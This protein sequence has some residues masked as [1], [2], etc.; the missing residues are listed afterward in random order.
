[1]V[2]S[3]DFLI[4]RYCLTSTVFGY[5]I[6]LAP[7]LLE[8][9]RRSQP[10]RLEL[11]IYAH[12]VLDGNSGRFSYFGF[13]NPIEREFFEALISVASIGPRAR[14]RARF[15]NQWRK[16][17]RAID[18]GDDKT[19]TTLP[20][21]GR[22]KAREII[23]K[24]QGKVARFLLIPSSEATIVQPSGQ[25][26][27]MGEAMAVLVQLGYKEVEAAALIQECVTADATISDVESLLSRIYRRGAALI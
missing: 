12:F 20:G 19:L 2:K 26:E 24:L 15:R 3:F 4:K 6:I 18:S 13:N 11:E 25:P 9:L 17:P 21:I 23:A 16:L 5:E 8:P 7:C 10:A 22:Q 14:R 1:M 27:F